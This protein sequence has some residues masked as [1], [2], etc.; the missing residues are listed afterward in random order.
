MVDRL[1]SPAVLLMNRLGFSAK[2]AIVSALFFL[3]MLVTN[4]LLVQEKYLQLVDVRVEQRGLESLREINEARR[5]YDETH[6]LI[7]INVAV[8]SSSKAADIGGEID[9]GLRL[10]HQHLQ[11][12]NLPANKD[13][14][15]SDKRDSLLVL[16][17]R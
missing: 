16:L 6:D 10:F 3:P 11:A 13:D 15:A 14:L 7:K 5:L 4:F 9:E 17:G 12:L 1:F 8:G 2:F